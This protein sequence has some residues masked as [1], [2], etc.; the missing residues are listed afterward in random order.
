MSSNSNPPRLR[1][2]PAIIDTHEVSW[3]V[4]YLC[5]SPLLNPVA[6]YSIRSTRLRAGALQSIRAAINRY[7]KVTQYRQIRWIEFSIP[8]SIHVVP[9]YRK[10]GVD[11]QLSISICVL[12][13]GFLLAKNNRWLS[14]VR[15]NGRC[16]LCWCPTRDLSIANFALL[17][18]Y[19]LPV[20]RYTTIVCRSLCGAGDL[21]VARQL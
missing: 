11:S 19:A 15:T 9:V 17:V 8:V 14:S 7:T 6:A 21:H 1:P 10:I 13:C 4:R 12:S 5:G 20:D 16:R 18:S 3:V 2:R